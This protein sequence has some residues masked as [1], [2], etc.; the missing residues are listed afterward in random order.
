MSNDKDFMPWLYFMIC[1]TAKHDSFVFNIT[2]FCTTFPSEGCCHPSTSWIIVKWTT[3]FII[4]FNK[5]QMMN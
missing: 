2:A 4:L 1:Q 5:L 3:K